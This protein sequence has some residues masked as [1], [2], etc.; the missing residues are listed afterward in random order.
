MFSKISLNFFII[1]DFLDIYFI[2]I[3]LIKSDN[4]YY[5]MKKQIFLKNIADFIAVINL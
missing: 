1:L 4:D 2:S 3:T 5:I